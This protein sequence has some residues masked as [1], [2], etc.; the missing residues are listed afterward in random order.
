MDLT[1]TRAHGAP[2]RALND[3][4]LDWALREGWADFR[5]KRG[6]LVLLPLIYAVMGFA[7]GLVAFRA[8]LWPLLFPLVAGFALV[9]PL[10]AAGFYELARRREEGK[11][12][13]WWHFLDPLRG[14]ARVHMLALAAMLAVL[15]LGWLGA[16]MLIYERTLGTLG[17]QTPDTFLR[18]LIETREGWTMMIVGNAVG[19]LFAVASLAVAAFSFPMVVDR[20]GRDHDDATSAVLT[21]LAVFRRNPVTMLK[22]GATVALILALGALPLFIGLMV[23]MPVLG[24]ATWHLYTRAVA[25]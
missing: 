21:S 18:S 17:P 3:G 19:A 5:E 6:D 14:P 16:A 23:A 25:R 10:A 12:S 22:W 2:V 7:I 8:D 24:Y 9:G 13:S 11:D 20:A 15:F 1:M 4:D